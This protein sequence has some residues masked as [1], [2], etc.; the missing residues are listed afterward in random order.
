MSPQQWEWLTA[1][2]FV[3]AGALSLAARHWRR[4]L[5][6]AGWICAA[7]GLPILFGHV[8]GLVFS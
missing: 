1:L 4:V 7:L 3:A 6:P 2:P 8:F 5:V